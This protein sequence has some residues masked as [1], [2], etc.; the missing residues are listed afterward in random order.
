METFLDVVEYKEPGLEL[1]VRTFAADIEPHY[2]YSP[3]LPYHNWHYHI[4]G[5]FLEVVRLVEVA[6]ALEVEV[7]P[8][9]TFIA[10]IG[11]DAGPRDITDPSRYKTLEDQTAAIVDRALERRHFGDRF[12]ANVAGDIKSTAAEMPCKRPAEIIT[13]RADVKDVGREY[14]FASRGAVLLLQESAILKAEPFDPTTLSSKLEKSCQKLTV[15]RAKGLALDPNDADYYESFDPNF[16][17]NIERLGNETVTSL[18]RQ[19]PREWAQ[20]L[21]AA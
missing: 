14:Y 4:G 6:E 11:H 9:E 13:N 2:R 15:I 8:L 16:E 19:H 12:R 7:D 1:G 10:Y 17:T 18:R 3:E 20:L 21:K 5:G